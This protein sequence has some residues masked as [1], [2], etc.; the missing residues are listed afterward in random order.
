M[1]HGTF[2]TFL[3][4]FLYLEANVWVKCG[5][6]VMIPK[7]VCGLKTMPIKGINSPCFTHALF[8]HIGR[9]SRNWNVKLLS[10]HQNVV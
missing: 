1:H 4:S 7:V 9:Q 2:T 5:F 10:N 3:I 6:N 8:Y